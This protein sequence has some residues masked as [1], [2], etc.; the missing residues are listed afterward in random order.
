MCFLDREPFAEFID[1]QRRVTKFE[2]Q[3]RSQST[4]CSKLISGIYWQAI[5]PGKIRK[6]MPRILA[7]ASQT[8][9]ESLRTCVLNRLA[10]RERFRII[11]SLVLKSL[12][13]IAKNIFAY[14]LVFQSVDFVVRFCLFM[15]LWGY[16][17]LRLCTFDIDVFKYSLTPRF[18]GRN[19]KQ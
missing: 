10:Y 1:P 8:T 14:F 9:S 16:E 15:Y 12:L 11:I 4:V 2:S 17:P 6:I 13:I 18:F 3:G 7:S 19:R 5:G